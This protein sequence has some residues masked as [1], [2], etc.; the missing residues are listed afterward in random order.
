MT[1]KNPRADSLLR[2]NSSPQPPGSPENGWEEQPLWRA[3]HQA[4]VVTSSVAEALAL[5]H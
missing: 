3:T 5:T 1:K 4:K 2:P